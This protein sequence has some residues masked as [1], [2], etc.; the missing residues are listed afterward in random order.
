MMILASQNTGFYVGLILS[1]AAV[2]LV[3]A[4]V[5]VILTFASRIA[6][7]AETAAGALEQIRESTE[8]L[9]AVNQTNE[10]ALAILEDARTARKALTG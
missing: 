9:P 8:I 4:L 1:F 2:A 3:V 5:A 7:Q 6:D 10:H